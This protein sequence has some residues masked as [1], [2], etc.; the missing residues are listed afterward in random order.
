MGR[1]QNGGR[2]GV[3]E[4]T[5]PFFTLPHPLPFSF[6]LSTHFPRGPNMKNA[7]ARP[8]FRSLR[9]ETLATQAMLIL[10]IV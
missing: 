10:A 6:L 1:E 2:K 9:T 8:E 3:E 5:V 7:F 4:G